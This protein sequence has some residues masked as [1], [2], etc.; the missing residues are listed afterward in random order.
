M[1]YDCFT[2]Y[3]SFILMFY[4][5]ANRQDSYFEAPKER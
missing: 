3:K 5:D 4:N 2:K 1:F